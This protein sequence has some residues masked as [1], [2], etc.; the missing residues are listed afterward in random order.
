MLFLLP[1]KNPYP[2]VSIINRLQRI[3]WLGAL[4]VT[5]S[6]ALFTLAISFGGNQYAWN[7]GIVIGFFVASGVLAILFALS[8]TIFP[9]QKDNS[10][11]P[12]IYFLRKDMLLLAIATGAGTSP[13]HLVNSIKERVECS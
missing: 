10:L 12:V 3:D 6:L 8:Q 1:S 5:S 4:L 13:F 2:N 9:W 7:S 11:F